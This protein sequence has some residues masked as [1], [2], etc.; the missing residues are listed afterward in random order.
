M[1]YLYA[2]LGYIRY[3]NKFKY[4]DGVGIEMDIWSIAQK[5]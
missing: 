2:T 4:Y 5:Q 1:C 3:R